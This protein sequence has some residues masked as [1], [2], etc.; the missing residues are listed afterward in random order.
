MTLLI[1]LHAKGANNSSQ[2]ELLSALAQKFNAELVAFDAP[3]KSTVKPD[4][5]FWFEK[6][7]I[8]GQR[9][10]R[11]SE[12]L[13]SMTYALSEIVTLMQEKAVSPKDLILCGHSQGGLLALYCGLKLGVKEVITLNSDVPD[14]VLED[15]EANNKVKIK[16]VQG[17]KDT[18]LDKKRKESYKNLPKNLDFE[19]IVSP[20]STHSRL[21]KEILDLL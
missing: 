6:D 9:K 19:Y 18:F 10:V 17:E 21:D 7:E 3:H 5:F 2:K 4:G 13:Y 15:I 1:F 14:E 12:W 11:L 20:N 8:D 16:W